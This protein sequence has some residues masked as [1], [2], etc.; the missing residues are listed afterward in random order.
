MTK[1][2][3]TWTVGFS[4]KAGRQVEDLRTEHPKVYAQALALAKEIEVSGP[5]RS[6]WT[7]FGPLKGSFPKDTFHCHIKSGKPTYVACWTIQ[8]K[9]VKITE[10]FYVGTHEK[11]PY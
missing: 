3:D 6:N 10:V 5:W 11:A 4:R 8:D 9:K 1:D 7:N 2:K